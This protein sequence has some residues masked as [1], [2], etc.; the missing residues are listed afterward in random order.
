MVD[1]RVPVIRSGPAVP[2]HPLVLGLS[3]PIT[4]DGGQPAPRA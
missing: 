3:D 1:F 2:T 4:V